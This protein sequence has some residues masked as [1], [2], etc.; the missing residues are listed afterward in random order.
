M[1]QIYYSIASNTDAASSNW[2]PYVDLRSK[3]EEYSKSPNRRQIIIFTS[4]ADGFFTNAPSFDKFLKPFSMLNISLYCFYR[5]ADYQ[6]Y[7]VENVRHAVKDV[8]EQKEIMSPAH[9][10][11]RTWVKM[12]VDKVM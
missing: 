5:G 6:A 4:E 11:V 8:G 3:L 10:L 7:C 1:K 12:S 2:K 9:E